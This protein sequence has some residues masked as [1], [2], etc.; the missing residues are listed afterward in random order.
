MGRC[1]HAIMKLSSIVA[2]KN[3]VPTTFLK[4]YL[5]VFSQVTTVWSTQLLR[6]DGYSNGG[7]EYNLS[8]F[9]DSLSTPSTNLRSVAAFSG[10]IQNL[11]RVVPTFRSSA[12]WTYLQVIGR[13]RGI[14]TPSIR[15]LSFLDRFNPLLQRDKNGWAEGVPMTRVFE[16]VGVG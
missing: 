8:G 4:T 13:K 3:D 1:L 12:G 15:S 6:R 10:P 16:D 5:Q 2:R 14:A 9:K 7:A 11:L